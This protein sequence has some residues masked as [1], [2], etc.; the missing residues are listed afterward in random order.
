MK[1]LL[2]NKLSSRQFTSFVINYVAG[3]GFITTISSVVNLGPYGLL[4]ILI[5]AFITLMVAL[6]FSRLTNAFSKSYGG[7]YAYARKSYGR[8]LTFF[9][10]WNQL[11]RTPILTATAPL[12]LADALAVVVT[13]S[14]AVLGIRIGSILFFILLVLISTQG[15]KLNKKVILFSGIIKWIIL[16]LGL[17]MGLILAISQGHI[18]YHINFN[19]TTQVSVLTIFS[20]VITFM[21]AFGGI[22][23][24]ATMVA[25][26]KTNN[27]RKILMFAFSFILVL[28]FFGYIVIMG[29]NIGPKIHN[30]SEVYQILTG[31]TGVIIFVIGL[32][33]NGISSTIGRSI[34]VA[35][36][37]LPLAED[38]Y[39]PKL[40]T[41]TNKSGE[42]RNGIWFSTLLTIIALLIFW[43]IPFLL[44]LEDFFGVVIQIG[45]ICFFWQYTFTM[46]SAIILE[47][48]KLISKIPWVEKVGYFLAI[49]LM[50]A[51]LLFFCF[52]QLR[53]IL[54]L[55]KTL[56]LLLS[57]L[58]LLELVTFCIFSVICTIKKLSKRI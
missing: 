27:F 58:S 57:T 51:A 2:Q 14:Q 49:L 40:F 30:F 6:T 34:V 44:H 20:N 55:V 47:R 11:I 26:V 32:I 28:Y 18:A 4:V 31:L 52:H 39:L 17:L 29:L 53:V 25:D 3:L 37:I 50:L 23:D 13:N 36:K 12:F 16:F 54:E 35:R 48:K 41:K 24:T 56:L 1:Q 10:G 5:T 45:V 9:V 22:D 19:N 8:K 33:F 42:L 7:S 15:L 21:F 38:G 46:L 43:L